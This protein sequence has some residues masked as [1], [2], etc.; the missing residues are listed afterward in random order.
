M[1]QEELNEIIERSGLE[2]DDRH[3]IIDLYSDARREAR[4]AAE[5]AEASS[6]AGIARYREAVLAAN[7][8]LP[9]AYINGATYEEIDERLSAMKAAQESAEKKLAAT[10]QKQVAPAAGL[11][12]GSRFDGLTGESKLAAALA[13]RRVS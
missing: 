7:P 13:A 2:P 6:K 5:A 12:R 3:R 11:S 4:E 1:T 10:I 8:D 9:A